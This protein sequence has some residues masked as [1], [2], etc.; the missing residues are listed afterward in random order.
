MKYKVFKKN[1]N[2]IINFKV[3]FTAFPRFAFSEPSEILESL[4]IYIRVNRIC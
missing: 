3:D 1:T 4:I 2:I